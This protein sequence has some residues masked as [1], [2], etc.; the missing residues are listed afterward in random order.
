MKSASGVSVD[1]GKRRAEEKGLFFI[2]TSALDSTNVKEAFQIMIREV[3]NNVRRKV[4]NS[5]SAPRTLVCV[6][7]GE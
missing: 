3:Y 7:D 1:E 6:V 2:E 4:L 5:D